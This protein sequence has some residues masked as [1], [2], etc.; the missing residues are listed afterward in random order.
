MGHS[1]DRPVTDRGRDL[2]ITAR[3]RGEIKLLFF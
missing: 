2:S 3:D 1:D